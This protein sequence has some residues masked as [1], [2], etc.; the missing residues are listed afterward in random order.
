MYI[1]TP[2]EITG[3]ICEI[4]IGYIL[5]PDAGPLMGQ[6]WHLGRS[7]HFAPYRSRRVRLRGDGV[8]FN[9]FVVEEIEAVE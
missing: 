2:S 6:P 8:A 3:T 7:N 1:P 9:Y 5:I 4:E